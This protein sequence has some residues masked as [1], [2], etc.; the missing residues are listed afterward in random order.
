MTPEVIKLISL[1]GLPHRK[2]RV[3]A[4]IE[5]AM[6]TPISKYGHHWLFVIAQGIESGIG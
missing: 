5:T 4:A 2:S 6:A 3:T 1:R